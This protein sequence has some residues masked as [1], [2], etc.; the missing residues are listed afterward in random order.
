MTS[1]SERLRARPTTLLVLGDTN[2]SGHDGDW[3]TLV[4]LSKQLDV[5]FAD[6]DRVVIAAHLLPGDPPSFHRRLDQQNIEFVELPVAGGSGIRAKLGIVLTLVTWIRIVAPLMRRASAVHLRTPCNMMMGFIPLARLLCPNRYAIYA[7]NWE[8]LGV[9][10]A[11]YRTQ[12]WMLHHFGGVVHAY[13]PPGAPLPP[14]VRPNVSPSFTEAELRSLDDEVARRVDRLRTDPM[15]DRELRLCVVG[16]FSV[17][18]NQFGV[19]RAVALLRDRGIPV[20]LRLAGTGRTHDEAKA[21]VDE[22]GLADQVEFLG[23]I[24]RAEVGELFAWADINVLVSRAEGFGKVFLEGMAHGCP[25]VCGSGQ[26]QRSLVGSGARGRQA[27]PDDPADIADAFAAL[28]DLPVD[29]QAAMVASCKEYV[30]AFTTEAFAREI[31]TIVVD[32][33]QLPLPEGR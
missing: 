8:P 23:H 10:P 12:R 19:I 2:Y 6:F 21:L 1:R 16:T 11:S 30:A 14:H 33:W 13:V 31:R 4:A 29:Q 26:M 5:W 15:A 9:E 24:G 28:R 22:L 17:R 3:H 7:D 27:D 32:L 18:K 20:R 25:A